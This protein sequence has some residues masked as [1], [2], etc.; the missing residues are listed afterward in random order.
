VC[1]HDIYI[2]MYQGARSWYK[3]RTTPKRPSQRANYKQEEEKEEEEE[4]SMTFC[5]DF[6]LY[7][8]RRW[9]VLGIECVLLLRSVLGLFCFYSRSLLTRVHTSGCQRC[10][11][12]GLT[13]K[14]PTRISS[15]RRPGPCRGFPRL[16]FFPLFPLQFFDLFCYVCVCVYI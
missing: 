11:L 12:E 4:D 7:L 10:R 1:V 6:S 13:R 2:Y 8:Q 16:M 15:A 3:P 5:G 9:S 14:F